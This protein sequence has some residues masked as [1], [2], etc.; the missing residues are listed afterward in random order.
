MKVTSPTAASND[1]ATL[2]VF[3][4]KRCVF[5]VACLLTEDR[6]EQAFLRSELCL[7]LR[8]YL[9]D[10]NVAWANFCTDAN[11]SFFVQVT[12]FEF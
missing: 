4:A 12:E 8:S 2:A 9:T 1:A 10:E 7:S 11:H 5:D 3:H 6:A